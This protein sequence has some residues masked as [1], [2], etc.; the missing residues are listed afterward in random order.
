MRRSFHP[1]NEAWELATGLDPLPAPTERFLDESDAR[2]FLLRIAGDEGS[3]ALRVVLGGDAPWLDVGR[4]DDHEVVARLARE[5]VCGSVRAA[6]KPLP[7]PSRI[8]VGGG[9]AAAT[10]QAMTPRQWEAAARAERPLPAPRAQP[11]AT[12]AAADPPA[13]TTDWIEVRLV[14][15]DG[16]PI[17]GERFVVVLPDGSQREGTTDSDGL[18]RL[19]NIASGNCRVSFPDLDRD[20]W[21]PV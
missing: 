14:G 15:E 9:T 19:D 6:R 17:A 1:G 5:L 20:A 4:M 7:A 11:A 16:A 3:A 2:S 18:A 8:P 10:S 12:E 21:V 13:P